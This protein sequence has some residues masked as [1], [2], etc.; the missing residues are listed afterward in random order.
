M[1][2][3]LR[4]SSIVLAASAMLSLAGCSKKDDASSTTTTAT[5]TSGGGG[6]TVSLNGAGATFPN[7]LYT[8]WISDYA[9]TPAG[10]TVKINYQSVGSGGGIKQVTEQTVDFG[11]S[12]APMT[13]EEL[14]KAP[15]KLVHI[16]TTLG[17]VVLTYNLD[18]IKTGLKLSPE[19]LA[20]IFLGDIKSWDDPKIKADNAT[21]PLPKKNIAIVHRTDGSGTTEVFTEYLAK[22]SPDWKS[23]VGSGKSVKW[24]GGQGAKGNEGVTGQ[25]TNQ[26][27]AIGY[28]EL[29]Y[30]AQNNLAIADLKNHAG[31][32][33]SP[34]LEAISAAAAAMGDKI[35]DDLRMSILDPDGDASYPISSFTYVLLY[36]D[37]KDAAKGAALVNF[38]WWG[39]HDGQKDAAGLHYATL[40]AGIVTRDE[41]KLKSITSGGKA[42]LAAP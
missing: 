16:P 3:H 37:Q 13:D 30:A 7:P 12:D 19:V 25:V 2:S 8:K 1:I 42:V 21:L 23:K 11:A 5:T 31:K 36:Q 15:G 20:G 32:F 29:A 24:P 18:G 14:A 33:V 6:G 17:A 39:I 41:A 4:I 38:L 22:I 27:G 9:G 10:K 26:S 28:V 35:P 34:T 40:P